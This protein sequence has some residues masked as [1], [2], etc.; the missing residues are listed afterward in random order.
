MSKRTCPT[1]TSPSLKIQIR[2]ASDPN[3]SASHATCCSWGIGDVLN[4][5][6]RVAGSFPQRQRTSASAIRAS[7]H[8]RFMPHHRIRDRRTG[9]DVAGRALP[10]QPRV[11]LGPEPRRVHTVTQHSDVVLSE[12]LA[13]T[14]RADREDRPAREAVQLALDCED[15]LVAGPENGLGLAHRPHQ[16]PQL[17]GLHGELLVGPRQAVREREVLL[18]DHRAERDGNDRRDDGI[19][20]VIGQ[21]DQAPTHLAQGHDRPGV[22]VRGRRGIRGRALE[23]HDL[24]VAYLARQLDD[25][26]DIRERRGAGGDEGWLAALEHPT[27]E[28][29]VA[30]LVRRDLEGWHVRVEDVDPRLVEGRA[31]EIDRPRAAMVSENRHPLDRHL[32]RLDDVVDRALVPEV[33]GLPRRL[34]VERPRPKPLKLHRVRAGLARYVDQGERLLEA[35]VVV[36]AG[37]RD[38]VAGLASADPPVA[39]LDPRGRARG[40]RRAPR[41][42]RDWTASRTRSELLP[43]STPTNFSRYWARATGSRG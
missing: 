33:L 16:L 36:G 26:Q 29:Q 22:D 37:L 13:G 38:D 40:H 30:H 10:D 17:L 5:F 3:R 9:R 15:L 42:T 14:D 19:P 31:E 34:R 2:V 27:D 28:R 20:R 4:E 32:H 23:K 39:D 43:S 24:L 7:R 11:L 21:A 18:D 41:S 8:T 25:P 35:P 12:G 6:C 1:G